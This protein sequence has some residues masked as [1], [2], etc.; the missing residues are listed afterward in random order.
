MEFFLLMQFVWKY[1]DD[2]VG[3]GVEWYYIAE[4]LFYMSA[5]VFPLALPISVL[6]SSIMTMGNLAEHYELAAFKSGGVSLYRIMRPLMV[7]IFFLGIGSYFFYN[8]VIPVANFKGELLLRN[9]A[10][11]KPALN[12]TQGV[13]YDGIEGYTIRVGKKYGEQNNLLEEIYIY[14]HSS[15]QGNTKVT[16]ART[17]EMT[18]SPNEDWLILTL[19]DGYSFE[20]IIPENRKARE[21][22]PFIKSSFKE[23]E[24]R[25]SLL[26][27][28][29]GNLSEGQGQTDQDMLN[30][31]QLV[32]AFDSLNRSFDDRRKDV[33]AIMENKYFLNKP[34]PDSNRVAMVPD[35]SYQETVPRGFM[36]R[37][38]EN[39]QRMARANFEYVSQIAAEYEWREQV[40]ARY[41]ISW[42]KKFSLSFMCFV[43]FFI[44]APLG[45]IIRKGGM[46]LPVVVSVVVFIIYHVLT[47]T[48]EKMARE[49]VLEPWAGVWISSAILLP[50]GIILTYKSA[51]D[52]SILNAE[53]YTKPIEWLIRILSRKKAETDESTP[54][55][56]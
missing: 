37:V 49:L 55:Q 40:K 26:D 30:N 32:V 28:K 6:L 43:L 14:D 42:H 2:L 29:S 7:F 12:I 22:K 45:A 39:A 13:F 9:I 11:Q 52:S 1:I 15:N 36:I 48:F 21:K 25:F 44:G 3:R 24:V 34:L 33:E 51:N 10:K 41:R 8:Y 35:R 56:Q 20:E 53:T 31:E 16:T 54:S 18:I 17:G 27:F 19:R 47:I 4:L 5:G 38:I 46:G 50:F 23:S